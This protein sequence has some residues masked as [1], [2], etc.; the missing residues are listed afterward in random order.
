MHTKRIFNC[1][2]RQLKLMYTYCICLNVFLDSGPL[3]INNAHTDRILVMQWRLCKW[4][5]GTTSTSVSSLGP[6]GN[7]GW[8]ESISCAQGYEL[9][10]SR[11]LCNHFRYTPTIQL[12]LGYLF[13]TKSRILE[14]SV[15][16][17]PIIHFIYCFN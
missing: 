8:Y 9:S 7:P 5:L 14:S 1:P 17:L 10:A 15:F 3:Y 4:L 11:M 6:H 13:F 16:C 2:Q 12:F